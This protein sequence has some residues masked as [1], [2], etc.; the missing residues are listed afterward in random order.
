MKNFINKLII[1]F[2]LFVIIYKIN[3]SCENFAPV[4]RKNVLVLYVFHQ[5]NERV[6]YFNENNIFEDKNV[7]FMIISNDKL[8]H[9]VI[10]NSL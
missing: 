5:Y 10:F 2:I 3:K 6:K 8:P 1:F 9:D 7:K 4:K